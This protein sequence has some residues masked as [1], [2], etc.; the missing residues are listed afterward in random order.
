MVLVDLANGERIRLLPYGI[1]KEFKSKS[2]LGNG[3]VVDPNIL[4]NDFKALDNN[5]IDYHRQV[6]LSQR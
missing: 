3:V 5:G 2:V 1:Q 6:L 4:L